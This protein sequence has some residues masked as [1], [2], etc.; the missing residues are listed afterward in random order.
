MKITTPVFCLVILIFI[1]AN[2]CQ[3]ELP[4]DL[5]PVGV[6]TLDTVPPTDSLPNTDS[7]PVND[8]N[9]IK[10]TVTN[11]GFEDGLN[12]W[13]IE[14]D[15]R[16]RYGFTSSKKAK[17][18]GGYGLNFYAA[19]VGHFPNAPQ[20]TPW[21]GKLYQTITGL[22]NGNYRF[23]IYADAVGEGMYLWANG[24]GTDVKTAIKSDS[25]E[26]NTIDFTVI[27]GVAKFGFIC[28]DADGSQYLA[29]YFHADDAELWYYP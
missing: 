8:T 20:E 25:S 24:G 3:K 29:P 28:I 14:T 4:V 9:A 6:D 5:K 2:A 1:I 18:S 11:P 27:N 22:Q 26:I 21:N 15:Y 16:G 10:I 7:I 19:Q 23:N 17:R 13:A 12:G